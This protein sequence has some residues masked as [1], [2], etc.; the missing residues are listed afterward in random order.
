MSDGWTNLK[1]KPLINVIV[2]NSR[3]SYFL[4]AEDFSRVEKTNEVIAE[5]VLKANDEIGPG[6][7]LQVV[8]DNASN[9]KA[10]GKEIGKVSE[11]NWDS[12]FSIVKT[13][14]NSICFSLN[15]ATKA[16]AEKHLPLQ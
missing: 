11:I 6:N 9:C 8:M 10:A 2:S 14:P 3:G 5:F 15:S 1:N 7:V 13:T 4:Y 12:H 16:H